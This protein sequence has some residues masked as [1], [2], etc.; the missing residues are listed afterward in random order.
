VAAN[1]GLLRAA[2]DLAAFTTD[3]TVIAAQTGRQILVHSYVLCS[4]G[5]GGKLTLWDGASAGN[6]ELAA[7][8]FGAA[9]TSA[10]IVAPAPEDIGPEPYYWFATSS[11]NALVATQASSIALYGHIIYSVY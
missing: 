8:S 7:L 5:G 4:P 11:G 10:P 9:G 1:P 3:T 6:R 2:I